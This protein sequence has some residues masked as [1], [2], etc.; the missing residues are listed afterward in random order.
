MLQLAITYRVSMLM[1]CSVHTVQ[2]R[3]SW[4][5]CTLYNRLD[6]GQELPK[7]AVVHAQYCSTSVQ[8]LSA[9]WRQSS[10]L[11]CSTAYFLPAR[12]HYACCIMTN[13]CACQSSECCCGCLLVSCG[14]KCCL[15]APSATDCWPACNVCSALE[16]E[17]VPP[18]IR[19]RR[20]LPKLGQRF[21]ERRAN[22]HQCPSSLC[23]AEHHM[24][25]R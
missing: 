15:Q 18:D 19:Q 25:D 21:V 6:P 9:V 13:C 8:K 16:R 3:L 20:N 12:V 24:R 7:L 5:S 14:V 4:D 22:M 1:L 10:L 23:L 11:H 2:I 17:G